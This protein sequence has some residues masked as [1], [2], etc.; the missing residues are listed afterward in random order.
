MV[1]FTYF[2]LCVTVVIQI[3]LLFNPLFLLFFIT[4]ISGNKNFIYW[5][6]RGVVVLNAILVVYIIAYYVYPSIPELKYALN[7]NYIY[8]FAFLL[9]E[10]LIAFG[11]FDFLAKKGMLLGEKYKKVENKV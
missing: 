9:L 7:Q 5:V 6:R 2:L 1:F 11:Y 8:E 3:L 10:F 4:L